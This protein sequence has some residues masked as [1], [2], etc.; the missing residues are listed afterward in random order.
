MDDAGAFDAADAGEL[1]LA[2]VE[3][4]VY[5]GAIGISGGGV[6]DDAV[7]FVDDDEVGVLE[8]DFE[9]D[10]LSDEVERGGLGD[11]DGDAVARFEGDFGL[12]FGVIEKDVSFFD[13]GLDA[14]A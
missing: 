10:V 9:G 8:E 7:S 12:H 1:S 11:V 5:E 13:E 2:M 4:G 6:D 3:E 14:R